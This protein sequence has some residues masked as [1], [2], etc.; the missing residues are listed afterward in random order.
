MKTGLVCALLFVFSTGL[1]ATAQIGGSGTKNYIPI[2][3]DSSDIG[4]S[5]LYQKNSFLGIRTT[6]PVHA[7]DVAAGDMKVRGVLGTK[8]FSMLVTRTTRSKQYLV[9]ACRLGATW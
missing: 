1:C 2:W 6:S 8:L 9:A 4:N 5:I 7:L 3:E